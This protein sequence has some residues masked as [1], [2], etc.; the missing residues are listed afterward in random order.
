MGK[1]LDQVRPLQ[2]RECIP[3]NLLRRYGQSKLGNILLANELARRH[4]QI[5]SNSVHPGVIKTELVRGM[6]NTYGS[7][8]HSIANNLSALNAYAGIM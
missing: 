3:S 8:V 1:H 5:M 4:P 2:Y 7:F 6:G